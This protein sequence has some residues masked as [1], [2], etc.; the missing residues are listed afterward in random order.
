MTTANMKIQG[1]LRLNS[2]T[3]LQKACHMFLLQLLLQQ[4]LLGIP[5][6]GGGARAKACAFGPVMLLRLLLWLTER[7]NSC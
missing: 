5:A 2:R 6:A 3:H 1:N 4:G 7:C